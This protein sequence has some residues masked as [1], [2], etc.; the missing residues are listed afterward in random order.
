[1]A[2]WSADN[3]LKACNYDK[4]EKK[5]ENVRIRNVVRVGTKFF[6]YISCICEGNFE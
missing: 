5:T 6:E 1:M 4:T 3:H 2:Y